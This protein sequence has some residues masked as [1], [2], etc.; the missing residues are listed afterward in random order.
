MR[1]RSKLPPKPA[2]PEPRINER[3]RV[4]EVRLIDEEGRQV[5][6][7]RTAEAIVMARQ[8]DVDLVEVAAQASPPVA[9]LMDFGRFKYEQS[10]KDREAKK[11]QVKMQLREVRMKP[12]IDEHDIDFK[13]RTAAKLLKQGDKVK[14]TV[15]FRGREITHPQI[16][17]NLLD[18][19]YGSLEGIA[20]M[21]K[22]AVLEGR[23]MTIILAPDKKKMA[24]RVRAAAAAVAAG[25]AVPEEEE[26]AAITAAAAAAPLVDESND[27]EHEDE[28][29]VEDEDVPAAVSE[30]VTAG[31]RG[32]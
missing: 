29:E 20:L 1:K 25:E 4:P 31:A 11:H 30:E 27:D 2:P 24:A 28:A 16:G 12:K 9:R 32:E 7:V 3:I 15:M 21:E 5:G 18:R 26:D 23:H 17:K 22:D 13:T 8:R 14:V 6:V 10:K 19:V